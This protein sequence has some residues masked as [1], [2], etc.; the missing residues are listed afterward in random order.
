MQVAK[1]VGAEQEVPDDLPGPGLGVDQVAGASG[2]EGR[3]LRQVAS[4][5]LCSQVLGAGEGLCWT[6]VAMSWLTA[7]RSLIEAM[8][9]S[10]VAMAWLT[11][12]AVCRAATSRARWSTTE[13]F[14]NL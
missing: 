2:A 4:M 11:F 10:A 8:G 13:S 14:E 5:V 12:L 3:E 6:A 9:S 7:V 1:G